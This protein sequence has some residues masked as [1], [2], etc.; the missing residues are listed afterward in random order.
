MK[1]GAQLNFTKDAR[2]HPMAHVAMNDERK[3]DTV[4]LGIDPKVIKLPDV[5]IT[6]APSNQNGIERV[7]QHL[8]ESR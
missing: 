1:A 4:Y 7:P 6:N 3:L 5:M 8:L 2:N